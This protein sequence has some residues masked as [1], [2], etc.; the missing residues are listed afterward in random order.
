M[1]ALLKALLL[2]SLLSACVGMSPT[3]GAAVPTSPPAVGQVDTRLVGCWR[4]VS[5]TDAVHQ[6]DTVHLN[7]DGTFIRQAVISVT[8]TGVDYNPE[9]TGGRTQEETGTWSTTGNTLHFVSSDGESGEIEF[10]LA[11]G[12]IIADGQTYLGGC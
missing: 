5:A 2:S 12:A 10:Q 7:A 11:E 3:N 8:T 4:Y 9:M 1:T 6:E